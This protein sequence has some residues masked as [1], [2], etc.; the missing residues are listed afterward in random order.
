MEFNYYLKNIAENPNYKLQR[1]NNTQTPDLN[2]QK[3]QSEI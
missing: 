2:N 1:T 3:K